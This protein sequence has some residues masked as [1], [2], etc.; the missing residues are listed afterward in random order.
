MRKFEKVSYGEY[1]KAT[2]KDLDSYNSYKLPIRKTKNSAGYDFESIIE[3]TLKPGESI[4]IPLGIKVIMNSDEMLML[5][6]RSSFGFKYNVR[7]CNQ[8]GII[9]SDFYNNEENEG[10]MYIKLQNEGEKDFEVKLKDRICQGIFVKFLIV[11]DEEEIKNKR[12]GGLG[13]T[14][15]GEL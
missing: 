8:I 6:N 1:K 2:G 3:F 10:H 7:M 12:S 11:D 5:V 13:S 4:K 15:K 14:G 9:E